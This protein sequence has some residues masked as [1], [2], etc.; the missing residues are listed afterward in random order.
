MD[1]SNPPP[2]FNAE[3]YID[4]KGNIVVDGNGAI[5]EQR[6]ASKDSQQKIIITGFEI[7]AYR[8]RP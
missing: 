4:Y 5:L 8:E 6:F 2:V 7:V 1:N 3:V